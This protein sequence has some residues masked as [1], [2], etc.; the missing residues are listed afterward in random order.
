MSESDAH[1]RQQ[2][3][4]NGLPSA[5]FWRIAFKVV[6]GSYD[7]RRYD[8]IDLNPDH[9]DLFESE[10]FNGSKFYDL[11]RINGR[12]QRYHKDFVQAYFLRLFTNTPFS[13]NVFVFVEEVTMVQGRFLQQPKTLTVGADSKSGRSKSK[14]KKGKNASSSL[15]AVA[16]D[17]E[18]FYCDTPGLNIVPGSSN[19]AI[20]SLCSRY[21]R[22][23]GDRYGNSMLRSNA[24]ATFSDG[25]GMVFFKHSD[26]SGLVP[27]MPEA[28]T[29]VP[30]V[31]LTGRALGS[32][33]CLHRINHLIGRTVS[34]K[35]RNTYSFMRRS[36]RNLRDLSLLYYSVE[37]FLTQSYLVSSVSIKNC[38]AQELLTE[39][40]TR[41][42]IPREYSR[43]KEQLEPLTQLMTQLRMNEIV[44]AQS[45][46]RFAIL[47]LG[48]LMLAVVVCVS[49]IL[50]VEPMLRMLNDLG[51]LPPGFL[52]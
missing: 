42:D 6:T 3:N 50:G 19:E 4:A 7:F 33:F 9:Y 47:A 17:Y 2:N 44:K 34:E 38:L 49:A 22:A 25:R 10:I 45:S 30:L 8:E 15:N 40:L 29:L 13:C 16:A 37:H 39:I 41:L 43:I 18:I 28:S 32:K 23:A 27:N 24:F 14:N 48:F 51:L 36:K 31:L 12:Y 11:C 26:F 46:L 52:Q 1:T 21:L 35:L 20:L 5:T